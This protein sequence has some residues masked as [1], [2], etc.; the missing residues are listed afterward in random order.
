V[1]GERDPA[2]PLRKRKDVTT[3]SSRARSAAPLARSP[4]ST[5]VARVAFNDDAEPFVI[6]KKSRAWL[7]VLLLLVAGG[8]GAAYRWPDKA[9]H[10]AAMLGVG[11]QTATVLPTAS[12]GTLGTPPSA[13]ES[14][15][16]VPS[17]PPA[18][19]AAALPSPTASAQHSAPEPRAGHRGWHELVPPP[20]PATPPAGAATASAPPAAPAPSATA[21]SQ[22]SASP[23][24]SGS[25]DD[26]NNPY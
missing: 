19:S 24:P 23:A 12:A 6:P 11:T 15:Q 26:P 2:I 7:W 1:M 16:P 5:P 3:S 14:P 9:R 10:Y 13:M 22:P 25:D 18:G 8:A 4:A 21:A 17:A 20:P